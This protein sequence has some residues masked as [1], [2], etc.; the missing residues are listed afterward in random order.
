MANENEQLRAQLRELDS[1][2]R[3]RE[4]NSASEA[5]ESLRLKK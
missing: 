2:T 1:R 4:D 3:P 5:V